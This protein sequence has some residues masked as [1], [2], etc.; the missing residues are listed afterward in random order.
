[1]ERAESRDPDL[2]IATECKDVDKNLL[3]TA[4]TRQQTTRQEAD[5]CDG[6]GTNSMAAIDAQIDAAEASVT[7]QDAVTK[8]MAEMTTDEVARA[9]AVGKG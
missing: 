7:R 9:K 8:Q 6:L 2:D 3:A 1:M 4:R 5:I